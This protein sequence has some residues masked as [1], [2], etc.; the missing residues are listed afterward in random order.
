MAKCKR[1]GKETELYEAGVPLCL[2]CIDEREKTND[3][4]NARQKKREPK[5]KATQADLRG[6]HGEAT[7]S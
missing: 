4:Q 7:R 3:S 1:C 2:A 6:H 5:G